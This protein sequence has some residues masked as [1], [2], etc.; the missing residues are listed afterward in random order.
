[1]SSEF[2]LSLLSLTD[3]LYSGEQAERA[4]GASFAEPLRRYAN[5]VA[6]DL[7]LGHRGTLTDGT[8]K[9]GNAVTKAPEVCR[10]E[11]CPIYLPWHF[12]KQT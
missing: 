12:A 4:D 11:N 3:Y 1:M 9:A 2:C 7:R 8:L 6:K 5:T 10:L